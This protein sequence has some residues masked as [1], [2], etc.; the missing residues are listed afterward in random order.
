MKIV[1]EYL[2][3]LMNDLKTERDELQISFNSKLI[4]SQE[5]HKTIV[6]FVFHENDTYNVFNA[7]GSQIGF[8]QKEIEDLK[9]SEEQLRVETSNL[10]EEIKI[11]NS[12][13]QDLAIVIGHANHV[14]EKIKNL[15]GDLITAN[16]DLVR[17]KNNLS[18]K[19]R[20]TKSTSKAENEFG[21]SIT[22]KRQSK[23]KS[24]SYVSDPF[25]VTSANT[26]VTSS[27]RDA[28][29]FAET[30]NNDELLDEIADRL[31][32]DSKIIS[33][34]PMRVKMELDEIYKAIKNRK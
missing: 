28:A 17:E 24:D 29:E 5:I 27:H 33:S 32:L 12:K 2:N 7:S 21:M 30:S 11:L 3:R 23:V 13:I 8:K 1:L 26:S 19:T 18:K 4:E 9:A 10:E 15:S 16:A 6:E 34:D 20:T 14:D 31:S 22:S 25:H